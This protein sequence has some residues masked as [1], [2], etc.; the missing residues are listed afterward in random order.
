MRGGGTA[1]TV[2][3]MRAYVSNWTQPGNRRWIKPYHWGINTTAATGVAGRCWLTEFELS[4]PQI[5]D[6]VQ[7]FLFA[8]V[9]GNVRVGIYGPLAAGTEETPLGAPLA[10]ESASTAIGSANTSQTVTF[11]ATALPAGR[12]YAAL[13]FSDATVTYGKS[14]ISNAVLSWAAYYDRA[15]GFGAFTTPCPNFSNTNSVPIMTV[16]VNK[17]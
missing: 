8:T 9:A 4:E 10:V 12:Y 1:R 15:G 7:F 5:L 3:T 2:G 13:Q 6:G 17:A 14:G 11:T 16:R